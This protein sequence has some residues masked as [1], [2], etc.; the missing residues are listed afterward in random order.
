MWGI[1]SKTTIKTLDKTNHQWIR[2]KGLLPKRFKTYKAQLGY[3]QIS[4]WYS[5]LYVDYLKVGVKSV[6]QF[7]G[8]NLYN[9]K[10]G[11]NNFFPCSNETSAETGH[12]IRVFIWLVDLP[13]TLHSDNN[14]NS[15]E[16]IFKQ[17]LQNFG[18]IPT[19]TEPQSTWQNRAGPTIGEVK[20][21]KRK[22]MLESNTTIHLWWFCYDYTTDT[23][24]LCDTGCFE[25]L[26]RTPYEIVMNYTPDISEYALFSWFQWSWLYGESLKSKQ[27]CKWLRPAN[28]VG[29]EFCP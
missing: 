9:N 2:S 10:L 5:T 17:L 8:G 6:I 28:G 14:K 7:I 26:G 1:G 29:Q 13:P 12:T 21:H 24:Y 19:Y 11:F 20:R 23:I 16:G 3:K 22:L 25:L 18:I 15:K 27:L 4:C